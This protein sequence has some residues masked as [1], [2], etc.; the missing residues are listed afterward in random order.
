MS[1]GLDRKHDVESVAMS[2]LSAKVVS[3]FKESHQYRR[4]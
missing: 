4:K 1:E 3:V 2:P